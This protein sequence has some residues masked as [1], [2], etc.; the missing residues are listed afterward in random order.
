VR[1]VSQGQDFNT[2]KEQPQRGALEQR[3]NHKKN[4]ERTSRKLQHARRKDSCA[5]AHI[6][7]GVGQMYEK[8]SLPH[9][10]GNGIRACGWIKK[11]KGESRP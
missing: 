9:K 5:E 11:D 10:S 8:E 3:D 6:I 4:K 2:K 1:G 7:G